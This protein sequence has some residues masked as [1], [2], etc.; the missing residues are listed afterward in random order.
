M[1][2]PDEVGKL[3]RYQPTIKAIVSHKKSKDET[4]TP[5]DLEKSLAELEKIVEQLE[6]GDLTL[7]QS[8]KQ[9][10]RGVQLTRDCQTALRSAEQKVEILLR[11]NSPRASEGDE[12]DFSAVPFDGESV[13]KTP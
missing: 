13:D 4:T 8:L 11:K 10:E 5:P 3:R 1:T 2:V 9:F 6:T 12:N 7:D